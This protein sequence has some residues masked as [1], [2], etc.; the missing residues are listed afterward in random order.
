V[1]W[2]DEATGRAIGEIWEAMA[3]VGLPSMA[4]YAHRSHRPHASLVVAEMLDVQPTLDAVGAVPSVPIRLS[5][6]AAGVFPG[7]ILFLACDPNRE[8]LAEQ[9]RVRQAVLPLATDPWP[10]FDAG[11]WTPHIT[12]AMDMTGGQLT[13]ALTV[14]LDRLPLEG[15]FDG[16]GVEDGT[17]G[18]RWPSPRAPG[19]D[20]A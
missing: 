3:S 18:E 4:T 10:Y 20:T 9:R 17:T 12:V 7:G 16:G 1:L 19:N 11:R 6:S 2:P 14:V 15:R 8:L 13:E 5:V